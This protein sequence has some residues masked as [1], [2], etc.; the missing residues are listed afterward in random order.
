M[1]KSNDLENKN[2][3]QI[4]SYEVKMTVHVVADNQ[5]DA[6]RILNEKGGAVTKRDVTL[7]NSAILYGEGEDK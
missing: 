3:A 5:L 7:L 1:K 2:V 6:E 4:F